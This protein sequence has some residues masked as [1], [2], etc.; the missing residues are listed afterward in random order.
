MESIN[1]VSLESLLKSR[2]FHS[3]VFAVA[4]I[5]LLTV[6]EPMM[7]IRSPIRS[8][9]FW[10][11]Y[12]LVIFGVFG[13]VYTSCYIGGR[14]NLILV[15]EGPFGIVRNPLY[16]CS[17]IAAFGIGLQS[18]MVIFLMLLL[19]SFWLYYPLVVA[20]EEARMQQQFGAEYDDYTQA[21]PRWLPNF[22]LWK[23]GE[24]GC[25]PRFIWN[26]LR[27]GLVFF[28]PLPIFAFINFMHSQR[29][30]PV[31]LTLP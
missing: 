18:G 16:L 30:L 19:V 29:V 13:R 6:C 9:M 10:L 21:V 27:D 15:K 31:W 14:K 4:L 28:M 17:F 7:N 23:S 24:N 26:A 5:L 22:S 25:P 11:G 12:V 3:R 20:R 8:S 1:P 2:Q